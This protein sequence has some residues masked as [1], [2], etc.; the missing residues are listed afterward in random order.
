MLWLR[1]RG[2]PLRTWR[3][4]FR[5]HGDVLWHRVRGGRVRPSRVYFIICHDVHPVRR[6]QVRKCDRCVESVPAALPPFSCTP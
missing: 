6:G 1:V 5:C 2:G 3:I 4:Y